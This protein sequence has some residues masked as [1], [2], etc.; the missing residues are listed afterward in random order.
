MESA[1]KPPSFWT[2]VASL[3]SNFWYA[4]IMEML[5]RLAFFSVIAIRSL[6][7]IAVGS[8]NGLGLSYTQKGWIFSI[9]ALLQCL[10]PMVSGGYTDRYGYRKSLAVAFTIN[11]LGY[12]LMGF[13]RPLATDLAGLGLPNAGFWVFL[14]AACLVGT[15]TAIFKPPVQGTIARAT[16]EATS[17]V[18]WGL[19]YWVVNIG[20]T[21]APFAAALLRGRNDWHFVFFAAAAVTALNFLP[22]FLLYREPE[23]VAGAGDAEPRKGPVGVFLHSVGTVFSDLR[24]LTFLLIVACFWLMFMQLW[25]LLPNFIDE[26]VDSS[27]VAG[28]FAAIRPG[29]VLP[30]GQVKPE[31][32]I[33]IDSAAIILLVIPI[34]WLISR[35]NKVVAMIV[36]MVI[37]LLGFVGTGAT[38]V[39]GVCCLMVFVFAI[40][41]MVCSPTFN[42]YV[43][44]IAPKDKKALYMGYSNIPFA[45]G[46]AVGNL[47]AGYMYDSLSSKVN[48]ARDYMIT[49]VKL[50]ADLVNNTKALPAEFVVRTLTYALESGE[51]ETVR[52]ALTKLAADN[53]TGDLA[54]PQIA[55]AFGPIANEPTPEA[56]RRTTQVLWDTYHPQTTWFVLGAV[57]LL[58]TVGMLIFYFAARGSRPP[59]QPVRP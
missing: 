35:I 48:L 1:Q 25:D 47:I 6:Y 51:N 19:F 23:P 11:I 33:N 20:G 43:G 37:A 10:I 45:I 22:A 52:A 53:A 14:C 18:G 38:M 9:W 13:S 12:L 32:I 50:P 26:W 55:A 59:Q 29:L 36:G 42:A 44:L 46:W 3:P 17:S 24:F 58:G 54:R 8:E 49:T 39:G 31:M 5:E 28:A 4:N 41:E 27:D 16:T 34:S 7:V 40:G 30:S 21:L 57:G 56:A 2:Q 15:G